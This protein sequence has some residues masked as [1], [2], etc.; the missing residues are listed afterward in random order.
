MQYNPDEL[1]YN[2]DEL[3]YNPNEHQY[4]PD[5]RGCY[6]SPRRSYRRVPKLDTMELMENFCH[7]QLFKPFFL[8]LDILDI[9]C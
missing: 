8:Y 3:Q 2:P 5:E 1:K 7:E 4:N 6:F 9:W